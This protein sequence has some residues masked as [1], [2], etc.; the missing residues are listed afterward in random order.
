MPCAPQADVPKLLVP[1]TTAAQLGAV[2][3]ALDLLLAPCAAAAAREVV[4]Q[5]AG[6][7]RTLEW[8]RATWWAP[9]TAN[10]HTSLSVL[11]E[12]V[13]KLIWGSGG[14]R[15]AGVASVFAPEARP[16]TCAAPYD[17]R[18]APRGTALPCASAAVLP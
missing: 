17:C 6:R 10:Q 8:L 3:A 2:P 4:C 11:L 14:P 18:F 9:G 15:R 13:Q 5:L 1:L 16:R 12:L 7:L